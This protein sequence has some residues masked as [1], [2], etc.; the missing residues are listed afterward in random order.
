LINNGNKKTYHINAW[1]FFPGHLTKGRDKQWRLDLNQGK[2]YD[3]E[4]NHPYDF[5]PQEIQLMSFLM[6]RA[7]FLVTL[8]G[9]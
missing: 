2:Y 6:K 5:P 9:H 7:T 8:S 1:H 3:K 4:R